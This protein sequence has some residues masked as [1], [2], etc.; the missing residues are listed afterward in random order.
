MKKPIIGIIGRPDSNDRKTPIMN[1][2]DTYRKALIEA[3]ANPILILPPQTVIYEKILPKDVSKLTETEKEMLISQIHL[4]DGFLMPGGFKMYEY[5]CFL[6]DY[7][8]EHNYPI[9]GI[10]MGMQVL[11][12]H[13]KRKTS[14]QVQHTLKNVSEVNHYLE[15]GNHTHTVF[16]NQHTRLYRLFEKNEIA[17]NSFHRYH[18]PDAIGFKIV[19]QAE[20]G[21]IEA[22][23]YP[24]KD[25]V[26]GVQWHPEKMLDYQE[27]QRKI[28]ED[29]IN[30]C[31]NRGKNE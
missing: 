16:L 28:F 23:E 11:A 17:V 24:N 20:D 2:F 21:Y 26:I 18:I 5:D 6:A 19:A 27:E 13:E 3:G 8:I 14:N 29:F 10:C 12:A 30:V 7:L 25:Y 4:C 15:E 9:L 22:I 31:R 1:V